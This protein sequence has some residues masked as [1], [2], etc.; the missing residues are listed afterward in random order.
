MNT[1]LYYVHFRDGI[2]SEAFIRTMTS[3]SDLSIE[4]V[5]N[6]SFLVS[7][8]LS[9]SKFHHILVSCWPTD[10]FFIGLLKR[11]ADRSLPETP[12]RGAVQ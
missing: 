9:Y 1:Y 6:G 8:S 3:I 4:P 11:C 5:F 2:T 12:H 7:T 10:A